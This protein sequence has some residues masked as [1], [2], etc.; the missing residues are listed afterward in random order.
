MSVGH[1]RTLVFDEPRR[2]TLALEGRVAANLDQ[3]PEYQNVPIR[4]D[5]LASFTALLSSTNVRGSIGR[6]DDE[7]GQKWTVGTRVY[8][9]NSMVFTKVQAT[10]DIG[11]ALP[12][13]HSSLWL[14]NASGF[15]PQRPD[16]PFA[17][18]FFGGFGNN[19]LD[20]GE[21]KRYREVESFPGAEI[22]EIGG[23]NFLRSTLEWTLPPR[24]FS[25]VGT[26]GAYLSWLRPA[27]FVSALLTNLDDESVRRRAISAGGQVDLRFSVL[28]ALDMTFSA[29]AAVRLANGVP[30]AGEFMASL[31]VLR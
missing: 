3:L 26:P 7:K 6:V 2:V 1:H 15:S 16:E 29:G 19:Y 13:G 21:E 4:V 14:R 10:Y 23:R 22:N 30:Q 25:R 17:N 12:L 18:F 31:R 27:L 20:H 24:R 28:S 5:R 9:V 11:C 8:Y